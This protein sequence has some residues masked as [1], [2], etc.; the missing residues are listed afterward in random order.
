VASFEEFAQQV[1]YTCNRVFSLRWISAL[2]ATA[3]GPSAIQMWRRSWC[4][5]SIW[6]CSAA[7]DTR[8]PHRIGATGARILTRWSIARR[9]RRWKSKRRGLPVDIGGHDA[10][11]SHTYLCHHGV[12][13]ALALHEV[14][15]QLIL[16]STLAISTGLEIL[17]KQVFYY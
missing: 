13:A 7:I 5:T 14:G 11:D 9:R 12:V 17:T 3:S 15:H 8:V 10:F 4:W 16:S 2:A 6:S 1:T